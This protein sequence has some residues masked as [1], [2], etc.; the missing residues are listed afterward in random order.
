M[1]V[2][3]IAS[4][5]EKRWPG[6]SWRPPPDM[7]ATASV[8]VSGES[9]FEVEAGGRALARAAGA[10]AVPARTRSLTSYGR[11]MSQRPWGAGRGTLSRPQATFRT[12]TTPG[13]GQGRGAK[14]ALTRSV[15]GGRAPQTGATEVTGRTSAGLL[16]SGG[17]ADL[18]AGGRPRAGR[19][20]LLLRP[21][22]RRGVAVPR[23]LRRVGDRPGRVPVRALERPPARR[24]RPDGEP[25][26]APARGRGAD[27]PARAARGRRRPW[28][29]PAPGPGGRDAGL[30][31]GRRGAPRRLVGGR[32]ARRRPPGT[33]AGGG[34]APGDRRP[35]RPLQAPPPAGRPGA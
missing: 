33:G 29:G 30:G 9:C 15:P 7:I 19:G 21:H 32:A 20:G 2:S 31:R 27:R 14:R 13:S 3:G 12:A 1:A 8:G 26:W 5:T 35:P 28:P 11:G 16:S 17:A 25:G 34:H 4:S 23:R 10:S 18:A 6:R 24:R 22:L